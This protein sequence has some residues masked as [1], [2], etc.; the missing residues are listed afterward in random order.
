MLF[1]H[2]SIPNNVTL[3]VY[4]L[5]CEAAVMS[6]FGCVWLRVFL[7]TKVSLWGGGTLLNRGWSLL[8]KTGLLSA[9]LQS[10]LLYSTLQRERERERGGDRE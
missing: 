10:A 9:R 5:L 7:T 3:A 4:F 6:Q 2:I 1:H 8:L